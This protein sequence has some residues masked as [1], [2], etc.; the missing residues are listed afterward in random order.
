MLNITGRRPSC[1]HTCWPS[2][3]VASSLDCLTKLAQDN[4]VQVASQALV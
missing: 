1:N 4:H 3:K 2:P